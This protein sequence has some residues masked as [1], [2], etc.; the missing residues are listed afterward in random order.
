MKN[1]DTLP[2]LKRYLGNTLL[3]GDIEKLKQFLA[4]LEKWNKVYNL[5]AIKTPRDRVVKHILDS[6]AVGQF[7]EG[8]QTLDVGTGAG[9][10]GIPLAIVY[11]DKQFTLLDSNSKKTAFLMQVVAELQLKNVQIVNQRVE[12]YKSEACFD[13]ILTRAFSSI[14]DMLSGTRH[15]CCQQGVFLAMKGV[16]PKEELANLPNEFVVDK[17]ECLVIPE[18][19]AER[20][21]VF[22]R[23]KSS[24][25]HSAGSKVLRDRV[26]A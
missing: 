2:L 11:P 9:L 21:L 12:S 17:V 14:N 4:L 8:D 7:L 1:N 15:L 5:T 16:Y 23:F 6:L 24:H 3:Q 13:I 22:I 18:L 19:M 26:I 10:P 25:C 20:H